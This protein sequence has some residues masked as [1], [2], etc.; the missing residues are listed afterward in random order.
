MFHLFGCP[1]TGSLFLSGARKLGRGRGRDDPSSN[2]LDL[3][4]FGVIRWITLAL[5]DQ[6]PDLPDPLYKD[7]S[8]DKGLSLITGDSNDEMAKK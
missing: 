8:L 2:F 7:L 3:T 1:G 4:E 5:L 6:L